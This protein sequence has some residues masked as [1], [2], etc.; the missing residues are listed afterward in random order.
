MP[1]WLLVLLQIFAGVVLEP[2]S[3]KVEEQDNVTAEQHVQ[4][5]SS[6]A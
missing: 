3:T 5:F 4:S 2:Y 1:N 6:G